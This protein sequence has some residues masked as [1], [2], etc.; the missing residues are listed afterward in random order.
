MRMDKIVQLICFEDKKQL[1][2]YSIASIA[3][4]IACQ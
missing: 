1:T 2:N 3:Y 4:E